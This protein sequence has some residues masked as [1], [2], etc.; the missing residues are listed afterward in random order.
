MPKVSAGL[1][2]YRLKGGTVEVLLVHPGGPF[3]AK[4]EFGAW[5]IPKGEVPA[6]EEVLAAAKREFEEET[7]LSPG[8]SM[9]PLG[10]VTQ[11]SGKIVY[12][13]AVEGDCNPKLIKSNSFEMEWPPRSGKKQTFPEIDRAAFFDIQEAKRRI[14]TAQ[15]GL[16]ARLQELLSIPGHRTCE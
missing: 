8:G 13:W 4:R 3:W 16:L 2:L 5:S 15:S 1:V 12:A 10:A 9:L 7:G 14:N 11:K 6:E